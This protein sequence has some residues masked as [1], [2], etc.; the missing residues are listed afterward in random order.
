M[1]NS[2]KLSFL[3]VF[4][5]ESVTSIPC[6]SNVEAEIVELMILRYFS[7]GIHNET[8]LILTRSFR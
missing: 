8:A 1:T 6:K 2:T 5:S 3:S 4:P 7:S